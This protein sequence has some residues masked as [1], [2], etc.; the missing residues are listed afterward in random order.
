MATSTSPSFCGCDVAVSRSSR[1][2][3]GFSIHLRSWALCPSEARY[4]GR[5]PPGVCSALPIP[6][7]VSSPT[8]WSAWQSTML[9]MLD[10]LQGT[11]IAGLRVEGQRQ[12]TGFKSQTCPFLTHANYHHQHHPEEGEE[13]TKGEGEQ[14]QDEWCG[15]SPHLCQETAWLMSQSSVQHHSLPT[16]TYYISFHAV[17]W[18]TLLPTSHW[19][20]QRTHTQCFIQPSGKSNYYCHYF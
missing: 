20:A 1:C 13:I 3:G 17:Q 11:V 14:P 18:R 4:Q 19:A 2:G 9:C 10:G 8:S 15:V 12:T 7:G 6:R 5:L 16:N